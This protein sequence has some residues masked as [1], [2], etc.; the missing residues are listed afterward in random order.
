LRTFG[1]FGIEHGIGPRRLAVAALFLAQQL[2]GFLMDKMK[3]AAGKTND[4]PIR[5][6]PIVRRGRR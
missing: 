6:G 3:P 2:S 5:V 1:T 4:W